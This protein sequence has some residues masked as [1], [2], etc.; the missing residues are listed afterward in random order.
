M[1]AWLRPP[2]LVL[3]TLGIVALAGCTNG[4]GGQSA[5]NGSNLAFNGAS[6]GSHSTHFTC[7]SGTLQVAANLG[8]GNVRITLTDANGKSLYGNTF[9][10]PGQSADEKAVSGASGQ[11]TLTATRDAGTYG[12]FSGQYAAHVDC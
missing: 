8:S 2:T 9:S 12:S 6:T 5:A 1:V 7:T 4:P 10:G 3:V 11:W